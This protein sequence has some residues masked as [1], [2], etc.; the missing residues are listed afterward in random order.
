M[1][2]HRRE[3]GMGERMVGDAMVHC[4][5]FLDFTVV[6]VENLADLSFSRATSVCVRRS[7]P[8]WDGPA[9]G[10]PRVDRYWR[11]WSSRFPRGSG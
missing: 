8:L 9:A 10:V 7:A 11:L 4:L 6:R 2:S 5:P 3:E 1:T